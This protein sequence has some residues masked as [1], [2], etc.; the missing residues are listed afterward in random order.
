MT[1]S[2]LRLPLFGDLYLGG[3]RGAAFDR[4]ECEFWDVAVNVYHYHS[5][6]KGVLN[7]ELADIYETTL[8]E[9]VGVAGCGAAN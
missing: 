2:K 6:C 4:L 7:V 3:L 5:T 9:A 1:Q 8:R